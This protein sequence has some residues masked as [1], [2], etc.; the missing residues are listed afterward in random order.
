MAINIIL[1]GDIVGKPGRQV[2][3]QQLP[4][5]KK[6]YDADL[7][8]A[9]AENIAGGS[10]ITPQLYEK[11]KS[12]GVHGVTLGDHALRQRQIY[13]IIDRANDLVRP[14]NL[15]R[16]AL[17]RG[18]MRFQLSHNRPPVYVITVLGRLYMNGPLADDPYACVE[19]FLQQQVET[20][21]VILVE[22]HA[23]ATSEKVAMGHFLDGRVAA[24]FGTH[25]HIATA[26]AKILPKGT[27]Y[28]TDLGMCGPYDSVIGRRKER[29]LQFMTTAMPAQFDVATGDPRLCGAYLQLDDTGKPIHIE[30]IEAAADLDQ[31]PFVDRR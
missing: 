19:H 4:Q 9:N 5:L 1:L 10:G 24:V 7:V 16:Q 6:Q 8:I 20:D 28:I 29:I 14:A 27:A 12:Y 30:R 31:P 26:D 15:P 3:Q 11:L 23:E 2:I 21:A 17:G 13:P 18:Y 22:I 25:T